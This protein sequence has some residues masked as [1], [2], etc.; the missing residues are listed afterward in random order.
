MRLASRGRRT[1]AL[2]ATAALSSFT[3]AACGGGGD[4]G[5]G[6]GSSNT[7]TI[8]SSIDQPVQDGMKKALEAK[9]KDQNPDI[10]I[11]WQK[12]E[13]INQLIITR[14]QAGDTPDIAL[15]PQPGV[16]G[17]MVQLGAAKPLDGI[18]DMS[19]LES[20]MLPG[21]LDAGKVNDQ[22]Y[23]LLVSANVKGL[24]LYNKKAWDAK[25]YPIPKSIPELESLVDKIK[26]D[27]GV[28]WCMGIQDPGGAT[29]W[30][31]T[32][33]F[34]TLFMKYFGADAYNQWIKHDITFESDQVKQVAD[35]FSKLL[36]TDGNSLGGQKAIASTNWQ[37]VANG[38]FDS[39]P[40][41]WMQM[42][43]SFITGFYPAAISKNVDASVGVFGFPPATAGGDN[44]VEGG[45]DML[46]VLNDNDQ[47]KQVVNDLAET[48]IGN[49]AAPTSTFISPHKDFDAS[50]YPND[51][52]RQVA[53]V[54]TGASAFLFDASD[55]MPAAV[56]A[57]TF[58]SEITA[59]VG[60]Q[61]DLDTALKNI[62]DSWPSS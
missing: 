6:G 14:I 46:T 32:D 22:L 18:V 25:G 52:T 44:P 8:W 56:G 28:P 43:G 5:G 57:G 62:D 34:E 40:K 49:D 45:G 11:N 39:Q 42:Q 3:L 50:L 16:V 51:F 13:N 47:V 36:F 53:A 59:W 17:Q 10:K 26:S 55:Q 23:G 61:E 31:A 19:K 9:L 15:I 54:A 20:S 60:G 29:G 33:W 38:M 4:G 30:P 35:E 41:C 2:M 24:V 48:D 1:I 7:V 58:W 37:T 27:G 12:V 21:S